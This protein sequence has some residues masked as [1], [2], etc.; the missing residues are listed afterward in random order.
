MDIFFAS[1]Q[2]AILQF[3]EIECQN[4]TEDNQ[5]VIDRVRKQA[6]RSDHPSLTEYIPSQDLPDLPFDKDVNLNLKSSDSTNQLRLIPQVHI[7]DLAANGAIKPLVDA[8]RFCG[9]IISGLSLASDCVMRFA[10]TSNPK[11][12]VDLLLPRRS[13]YV[14]SGFTRYECTHEIFGPEESFFK[15]NSIKRERR[16]SLVCRC[17]PLSLPKPK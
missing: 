13:L 14:M 8:V 6:F 2:K 11:E 10:K 15:G 16:V 4:W 12:F 1:A 9:P 5:K 3:R 17:L 7:L